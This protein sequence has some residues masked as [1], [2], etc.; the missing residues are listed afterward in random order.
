MGGTKLSIVV[1]KGG[2]Q[3]ASNGVGILTAR[4]IEV[5]HWLSCGKTNREIALLLR[6]SPRTIDKHVEHILSKLRVENR[7]TAAVMLM[8]HHVVFL[9]QI[10][11]KKNPVTSHK[12]RPAHP[13]RA[14]S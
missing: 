3:T 5:G 1:R 11:T 12:A 6:A 8:A 10:E 7:T 14:R 4:E 9:N 2:Q 13:A